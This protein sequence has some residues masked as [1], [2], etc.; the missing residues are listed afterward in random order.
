M[1][2]SLSFLALLVAGCP[3]PA[4][5]VAPVPL[6]QASPGTTIAG[7]PP[8]AEQLEEEEAPASLRGLPEPALK[9]QVEVGHTTYRTT[10]LAQ[11]GRIILGSNGREWHAATDPLDG[12]WVLAGP[13]GRQLAHLM[14]PGGDE[15]DV[16][17]VAVDGDALIFGT[18][19]GVVYK[20][21]FGGQVLWQAN[22]GGDAE[23]APGLYDANGDG[24]LDVAIG[25]EEG[26]FFVLDGRSGETLFMIPSSRGDY[27]QVG[28]VAPPALYDANGDGVRDVFAPGR[29]NW[30]HAVDGRTGKPLWS[31]QHQ[32]GLHGAPIVT[33]TDRDGRPEL[34]YTEAYSDLHAVDPSSGQQRWGASLEHPSMGIE[35]LFSPVTWHPQLGCA[36]LGTAWWQEQEGLYCVGPQGMLWRWTEPTGNITSGAVVG[37]VDGRPGLEVVF[38]TE[39]GR[40]L[41][42]DMAGQPVWAVAIGA[43]IECTPTLADIDGDGLTEVLVAANDG[44]LRAYET[45][46]RAPA[47]LGYHRG[48]VYNQGTLF[49]EP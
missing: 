41:A 45:P 37:D 25:A 16:N 31:N 39:S 29:D 21:T 7:A 22:I 32:S 30:L 27:G 38:G 44:F 47:A 19:Q 34:I 40:L 11:G 3:K 49:V 23:A 42:L 9:W 43:P 6:P 36:L 26:S 28:F 12:V 13:D 14:P 8:S 18:D 15:K 10:L 24:V 2:R 20:S 4:P 1:H 17:G 33:D 46:G 35:G 48:D 5:H